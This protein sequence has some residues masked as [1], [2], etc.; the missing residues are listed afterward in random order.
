MNAEPIESDQGPLHA[1]QAALN[2]GRFTLQRCTACERHV[3]YP[4]VLC[5]HCGADALDWV[6]PSGMGTVYSVTVVARREEQGGPYNVALV[7]LDEGVRL[8]SRVEGIAAEDVKI[9]MRVCHGIVR[10][11]DE[12]AVLVFRPLERQSA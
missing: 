1:W 10:E 5:P 8:M 12:D 3:F 11:G 9:D 7:D 6:E 2:E 4:R